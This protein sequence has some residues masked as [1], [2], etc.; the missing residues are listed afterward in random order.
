MPTFPVTL[1]MKK[2]KDK[3]VLIHAMEPYMVNGSTAPLIINLGAGW[4]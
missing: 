3:P 1:K 4:R 2:R